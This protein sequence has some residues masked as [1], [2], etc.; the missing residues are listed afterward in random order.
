MGEP[1]D[2]RDVG[3][4][5]VATL[6]AVASVPHNLPAQL[7]S[8]I[9]REREL[10]DITA[11]LART[12]ILTLTG[13]GGCGKSRLAAQVASI[14]LDES[15]DGVWWIELAA[16]TDD[17]QVGLALAQALGVRPSAHQSGTDAAASYLANRTA[18]VVLDN[19]EHLLD[20]TARVAEALASRC[21]AVTVLATSR[22]PM[23][24][25]GETDWRVP[26]LSLPTREGD[27]AGSDAVRL[28]V[29]R[30]RKVRPGF[31]IDPDTTGAVARICRGLDGIPL[32]IELAAARLRVLSAQ[33][34]ADGLTDR[35]RILSGGSR[36]A[37]TR[38]RTLR[39]SVDWSHDLLTDRERTLFRR[40]GIFLGGCTLEIAEEVCA[41]DGL[42]PDDV[43]DVITALV[44]KSLV[45]A[46]DRGTA[47]RYRLLE[48]IRQYALAKLAAAGETDR[49]RDAHRDAYVDYAERLEPELYGHA[50]LEALDLLDTEA[51]NFTQAIE[52]AARTAPEKGIRLCV[53]LTYWWRLRGM[54]QQAEACFATALDTTETQPSVHRARALQGRSWPSASRH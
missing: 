40:L 9:G 20:E 28:F 5:T 4:A 30:A 12:R 23:R 22:E 2:A 14:A 15:P 45:Q 25:D 17:H 7:S 27:G 50:Q 48:T 19:C 24:I 41:G 42:D 31:T 53:A 37:D 11:E 34:I 52:R 10:T 49:L 1:V 21:P 47:V 13:A 36:S 26:S 39:A 29:D 32:A 43:L 54:F 8:F 51:A 16:L 38:H 6:H 33:Q 35:F 44:D 46:E 18:V 3:S